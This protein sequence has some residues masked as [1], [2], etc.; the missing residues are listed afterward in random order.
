MAG[1]SL[2]T[3]LDDIATMLDDIALMSKMAAKKTAGVLGDDLALNAQQVS[4]VAAERELPVV[5]AVAKGS[6]RNKLI[7]VP[8]ALL[9]S[10][11]ASWVIIPLLVL[12]GCYLCY[13]GAEKVFFSHDEGE[14]DT[15]VPEEDLQAY[16]AKKV[17]GAIRTD[18]ILSAEIIV[19]ALGTVQGSEFITQLVVVSLIAF[20]MTLGVYGIVAAIVKLDDLGF[21]LK[22]KASAAAQFVGGILINAAP[23]MMKLLAI[24]GT[25]AM[26]LVGGGIMTHNI[27]LAHHLVE[28]G[29]SGLTNQSLLN[30]ASLVVNALLGVM[31]GV[32]L[33]YGGSLLERKKQN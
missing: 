28:T 5:W 22:K 15:A 26:F 27:P 3:L 25:I 8:L 20:V 6:L 23:K 31:V 16:E 17:K 33:A 18:F 7:L 19:I 13:E 2:L 32:I 21:H 10:Y 9:L 29:L 24:V 30:V 1:A 12:G 11:F 4:G 14:K